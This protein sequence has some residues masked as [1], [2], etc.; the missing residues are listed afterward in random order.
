MSTTKNVMPGAAWPSGSVRASRMPHS[1]CCALDVHTFWPLT[2]NSS[3]S[4]TARVRQRRE[5]GA[6]LRLAEQL[7]PDLVAAEDRARGSAAA[8]RARGVLHDRGPD[9]PDRDRERA[10]RHAPL[11]LL[12]GED[13]LLD[14]A[15]PLPA[16]RLRPGDA[17]EAA[18]VELALPPAAALDVLARARSHPRSTRP[19]SRPASPLRTRWPPATPAPGAG[20]AASSGVSS[21][22]T[23]PRLEVQL[24]QV[25]VLD[26]R[27]DDLG[28]ADRRC[29]CGP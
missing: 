23:A 11:R 24:E 26:E 28:R 29:R 22:S 17:G 6:G 25:L 19:R 27:L 5:V 14:R 10:D 20:S 7:A 12:L 16:E 21:K 18:L 9:H 13:R 8:G 15:A 2:T 4:R 1:L 3:P